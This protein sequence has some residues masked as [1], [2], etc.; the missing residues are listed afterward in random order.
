MDAYKQRVVDEKRELDIKGAA[1]AN[2]VGSPA[3]N[4]LGP[5][6]QN[7]LDMQLQAMT[8]YSRILKMR[9]ESF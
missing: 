8:L 2:F 5:V 1:L 4:E 7:H 6:A 3:Y 9:I